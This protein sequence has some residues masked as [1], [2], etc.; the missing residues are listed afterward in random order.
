MACS[1]HP[2]AIRVTTRLTV[3]T[4]VRRRYQAVPFVVLK[5]LW[6]S[7][8]MKRWSLHEW[9]RILPWPL[10]PLAGHARLGQNTVVG[11]MTILLALSGNMPKRSMS[12]PPF[13]LQVHLT[14]V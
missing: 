12:G 9:I 1:G 5:V 10:W 11:F 7:V 6:H 2:W 8:D 4:G 3:S 14:T 13:L